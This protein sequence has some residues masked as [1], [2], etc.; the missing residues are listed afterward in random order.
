MEKPNFNRT[1][2]EGLLSDLDQYMQTG[3][4]PIMNSYQGGLGWNPWKGPEQ[5]LGAYNPTVGPQD[6]LYRDPSMGDSPWLSMQKAQIGAQTGQA[7]DEALARGAQ[8]SNSAWNQLAMGGGVRSGAA[9]NLAMQ[10][11]LGGQ[12]GAQEAS[13]AG[14]QNMLTA[15]IADQ[16]QNVANQRFDV[17]N[18]IADAQG[19][20]EYDLQKYNTEM[21]AWAAGQAAQAMRNSGKK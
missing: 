3:S 20:N 15:G 7:Q 13:Y 8:A 10:G 12:M 4:S 14:N 11:N 5:P 16:E 1:T 2:G 17:Q 9:Q 18:R 19:R 21:Q 6:F